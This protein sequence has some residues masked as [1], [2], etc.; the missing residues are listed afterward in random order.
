MGDKTKIEWVDASWNPVTVCSHVSPDA[1]E[2]VKL[3][4][5]QTDARSAV[6]LRVL[7]FG[8]GVQT[9]ALL[10]LVVQGRLPRPDAIVF[11]DTGCE[12]AE[13]YRYLAEVSGPYARENGLAI[14]VLGPEWRSAHYK[15]D[16]ETYCLQHRMLPG[17]W[18]RWC[19]GKYKIRPIQRFQS[20]SASRV[21]PV[22]SW[23]G[24]STDEPRRA[25]PSDNQL[26]IK[27]YPLIELGMDRRDCENAIRDA[28]LPL[29]PKSGCWFCP[30][31]RQSEWHKL[32]REHPNL[33]AR[34]LALESNARGRD[35][36]MRYLPIFGSLERVAAQDELP[37]FDEAIE[38]EA[39]CVTG[40]CFV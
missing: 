18:V 32:K 3:H 16:L 22:E 9:T 7:S 29:P 30:F 25:R 21:N 26:E 17:T 24:I 39:G 8:A 15:P 33:F 35:G 5:E 19:T 27:R 38:A 11:A 12:S 2:N 40:S 37:G 36:K 28:G 14:T 31:K 34:A 20:I 13:T 10:V 1:A 23:I 6:P 4:P